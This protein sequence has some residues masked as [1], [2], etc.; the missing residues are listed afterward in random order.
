V[1]GRVVTFGEVMLRLKSPSH[2]RLLQSPL[3]EATFGGGEANVAAS[4][5]LFGVPVDFVTALPANAIGDACCAFL[6]GFGIGTSHIVRSGDRLGLYFLEAGSNQRPSRVIYDRARSALAEAAP[7]AFPWE[8]IFQDAAWF[9][10]TGITPALSRN[11]ADI[12]LAGVRA[13]RE[14]GLTVS[15]D[16]NYRK[17][18]WKYGRTAPE[19]MTELVRHCDIGIANEEDCQKA[20]GISVEAQESQPAG[21]AEALDAEAYRRLTQ[22]VLEAFPGL[23]KQAI[24]LRESYSADRNGWSACLNNRQDFLHSTRYEVLDV[25]D[26]VGTGDAFAAGLIRGWISGLEDR[27]ALEFAVAASCLKHTIPGDMNRCTVNEVEQLLREGGS[28]RIKR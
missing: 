28:G 17:N 3:L 10:V 25:V 19:V 4:L 11:S 5:A 13:A 26:R 6:Q 7:T 14:R 23:R 22:K 24:T 9:H 21:G 27:D 15:C 16:Y 1:T 12:A 20:L 2:E 18:L 8:R